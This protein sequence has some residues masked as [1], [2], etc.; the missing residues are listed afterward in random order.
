[1]TRFGRTRGCSSPARAESA[2]ARSRRLIHRNS[3][4]ARTAVPGDQL[5]GETGCAARVAS[6]SAAH[7]PVS[8]HRSRIAEGCSNRRT[9]ARSSSANIGGDRPGAPGPAAAV[10]RG[11]RDPARRRGCRAHQG[12]RPGDFVSR[13]SPVRTDGGEDFQRR[14]LLP[15]ERDPSGHAAD[16]PPPARR[17]IARAASVMSGGLS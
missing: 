5:C 12:R 11:R 9:A 3:R 2:R 13:P 7:A 17:S 1:M 10:S 14:T 4:R 6:C 15:A 8:R 16:R